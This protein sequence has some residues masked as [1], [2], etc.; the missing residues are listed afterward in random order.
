MSG[1]ANISGKQISKVTQRSRDEIEALGNTQHK[2]LQNIIEAEL[3]KVN[4]TLK[5]TEQVIQEA[6]PV[7]VAKAK[8]AAAAQT[9]TAATQKALVR[10]DPRAARAAEEIAKSAR[11]SQNRI[12][13]TPPSLG[14]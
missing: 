5:K 11:D 10:P 9:Q 3:P 2:G 14:F 7:V 4:N 12:D 1:S 6:E 13:K 8:E